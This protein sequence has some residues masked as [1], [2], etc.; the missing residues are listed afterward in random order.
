M[1]RHCGVLRTRGPEGASRRAAG[2]ACHSAGLCR[3]P[4]GLAGG[5]AHCPCRA[6]L[7]AS[8][9]PQPCAL[10]HLSTEAG[11]GTAP[12]AHPTLGTRGACSQHRGASPRQL[13]SDPPETPSFPSCKASA[14]LLVP[15]RR[16]WPCPRWSGTRAPAPDASLRIPAR[17]HM[18]PAVLHKSPRHRGGG[19]GAGLQDRGRCGSPVSKLEVPSP[20]PGLQV[21]TGASAALTRRRRG[22]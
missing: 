5:G 16:R 11:V 7:L 14:G 12:G 15:A 22:S 2:T 19:E 6:S 21:P 17:P 8:P 1:A 10:A 4:E 9:S 3:P 18:G 20:G 13:H